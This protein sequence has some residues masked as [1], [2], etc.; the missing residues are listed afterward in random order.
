MGIVDSCKLPY[1]LGKPSPTTSFLGPIT[2]VVVF[3]FLRFLD[4]FYL[5][6]KFLKIFLI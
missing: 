4:I 1:I 2:L 3:M 6:F 5:R